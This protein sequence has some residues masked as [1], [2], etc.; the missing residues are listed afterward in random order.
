MA[1]LSNSWEKRTPITINASEVPS[2]QTDIALALPLDLFSSTTLF[3]TVKAGGVDIRV[4]ESDGTTEIPV[5]VVRI[6]TGGSTGRIYIKIPGTLS[7][8]TDTDLYI[9]YGNPSAT[10]PARTSTYG[11]ENVWSSVYQMVYHFTES[12]PTNGS[13]IVD[14]TSNNRDGTLGGG[15]LTSLTT[16]P[17]GGGFDWDGDEYIGLGTIT[18]MEN[19][20]TITAYVNSET[21]SEGFVVGH[22]FVSGDVQYIAGAGRL[23]NFKGLSVYNPSWSFG[24]G[25]DAYQTGNWHRMVWTCTGSNQKQFTDGVQEG[26]SSGT[27]TM[28]ASGATEIGRYA[29]D[30]DYFVGGLDAFTFS[31][32]V[33][34]DYVETQY[35]AAEDSANFYTIGT[36]E[37]NPSYVPPSSGGGPIQ[38]VWF[39]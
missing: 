29:N 13:T 37:T 7:S 30:N 20:L 28:V 9:N 10:L 24:S 14:S 5:E 19:D 27:N 3:S 31:T 2:D 1:W 26:S 25:F 12:S 33:S 21:G 38:A 34:D 16:S 6:D 15:N 22:P 4:T 36:E 18:G 11:S 17:A 35:N 39:M 32:Y 8:S 23:R